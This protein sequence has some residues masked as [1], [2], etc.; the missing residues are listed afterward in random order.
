MLCYSQNKHLPTLHAGAPPWH[1]PRLT[2]K[3]QRHLKAHFMNTIFFY[4]AATSFS[5]ELC[6]MNDSRNSE[7]KELAAVQ[8]KKQSDE[9]ERG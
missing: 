1:H 6:H 2:D 3:S 4:K 8:R 5:N 7:H 9:G